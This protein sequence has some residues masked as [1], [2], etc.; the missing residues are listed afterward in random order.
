[1]NIHDQLRAERVAQDAARRKPGLSNP[2]AKASRK[3]AYEAAMRDL[4]DVIPN[5]DAR[6]RQAMKS[7]RRVSAA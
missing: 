3:R 4:A 7:A 5:A 2:F 1:M 6:R